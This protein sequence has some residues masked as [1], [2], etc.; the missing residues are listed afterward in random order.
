MGRAAWPQ[1]LRPRFENRHPRI[2]RAH[3]RAASPAT[4][5]PSWRQGACLGRLGWPQGFLHAFAFVRHGAHDD[6][7]ARHV[8]HFAFEAIRTG[9]VRLI[10][11][12]NVGDLHDTRLE[13][14]HFVAEPG[15]Q[16]DH[17]HRR[18]ARDFRF[19]L[20]DTHSLDQDG[21]KAGGIEKDGEIHGCAC[22]TTHAA[23]RGHGTD[24]DAGIVEMALHA[25]AIAKDGS[26]G[27][28]AG[29][30]HGDYA[31]ALI[32]TAQQAHQMVHQSAL[33]RARRPG[34]ADDSRPSRVGEKVA[35]NSVAPGE[36]F[37]IKVAARASAR[38]SPAT[39][40]SMGG[41]IVLILSQ[42]EAAHYNRD[43]ST[44][45]KSHPAGVA[46]VL[47]GSSI[48]CL[49]AATRLKPEKDRSLAPDFTLK[50]AN[51]ANVRL[52]DYRGKVVLLDFWA[53]W[54]GPCQVEIPWFI[55]FEQSLKG[56]GFEVVGVSMDEDGWQVVKPYIREAQNELPR[57]VGR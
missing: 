51:G 16:Q 20:T 6:R 7:I 27:K 49:E 43:R 37:S 9:E 12:E 50:D 4:A 30:V 5:P 26:A 15:G 52:S 21:V 32:L 24:E 11:D 3:G 46:L 44:L 39:I 42:R 17:H 31:D 34:D 36:R 40:G 56:K 8:L 45:E 29:G 2:V 10:E 25:D 57:A 18:Q 55:E 28:W 41:G 33:A 1:H 53:T 14:L 35:G 47:A 13:R 38:R 48:N 23:A 54:C 22:D 19:V